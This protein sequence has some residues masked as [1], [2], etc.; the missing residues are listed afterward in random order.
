MQT[1]VP[2][3]AEGGLAVRDAAS[4]EAAREINRKLAERGWIAPA[5]PK[6]YGGLGAS[7]FEQVVFNKEFGYYGVPDTGTRTFGVGISAPR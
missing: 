5:W 2:A 3:G 6:S 7:I 4:F 1:N